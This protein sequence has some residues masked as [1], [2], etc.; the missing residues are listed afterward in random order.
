MA[1]SSKFFNTQKPEFLRSKDRVVNSRSKILNHKVRCKY[2]GKRCLKKILQMDK[3][4]L[5]SWE[6]ALEKLPRR[7][8]ELILY[9]FHSFLSTK[10]EN[11]PFLN[12]IFI[13]CNATK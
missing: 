1:K 2:S 6:R 3:K 9:V 8:P 10:M 12:N 7:P 4:C 5:E 11:I 13:K